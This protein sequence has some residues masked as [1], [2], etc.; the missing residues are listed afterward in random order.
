MK[1]KKI[2]LIMLIIGIAAFFAGCKPDEPTDNPGREIAS[3][4]DE[5]VLAPPDQLHLTTEAERFAVGSTIALTVESPDGLDRSAQ[6]EWI[7]SNPDAVTVHQGVATAHGVGKTSVLARIGDVYS[8]ELILSAEIFVNSVVMSNTKLELSIDGSAPIRATPMPENA[9]DQTLSWRCSDPSVAVVNGG[10]VLGK[11]VGSC[12][13]SVFDSRGVKHGECAVTVQPILVKSVAVGT[14]VYNLAVGQKTILDYSVSPV[15][16]TNKA[17]AWTSSN[18]QIASVTAD[19]IVTAVGGGTVVI[20]CTSQDGNAQGQIN[21]NVSN[22]SGAGVQYAVARTALRKGPSSKH[23]I[24]GY[25]D[26]DGA[27]TVLYSANGWLLVNG[28]GGTV[29]YTPAADF[30]STRPV[31]ITGV[32]YINQFDLGLYTGCEAVSATML[33]RYYGYSV[34]AEQVVNATPNGA[35]KHREG[36]IW[37]GANPFEAFVG[38]PHKKLNEGS[39]GVFAPPIVRAMNLFCA[40]RAREVSGCSEEQLYQYLMS[41]KPVVVWCTAGGQDLK[42]G[43]VWHYPDGSG[44]FQELVNQHCAVLIGMDSKYVYLNDPSRGQNVK[45]LKSIFFANW[46]ALH[47]QAIILD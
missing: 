40:G 13:L 10:E 24:L 21:I 19:G 9:T 42:P 5:T 6:V 43:V 27:C 2:I 25:V 4:S 11:K 18:S 26:Q 1:Q 28:P 20:A 32:P 45:Q 23:S 44:T 39:W 14:P 12:T 8:N 37:I 46:R 38:D 16:A 33:M 22:T 17:V 47:A 15:N 3:L 31:R 36:D 29:G 7:R 35:S 34:Q 41:G 30:S